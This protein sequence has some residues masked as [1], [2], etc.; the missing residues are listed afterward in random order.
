MENSLHQHFSIYE[1]MT[2]EEKKVA[3][4]LKF[5]KL[6]W[7]FE[8]PL[9]ITDHKDRPRIWT[10]DFFL[11]EFGI[12]VEV[13]GNPNIDYSFRQKIYKLENTPIIFV[14]TYKPKW[15]FFLLQRIKEIQKK[16]SILIEKIQ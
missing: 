7:V 14:H 4:F 16:R 11:S 8:Q 6:W 1:E 5:K 13:C 3:E 9:F 2:A 10:P 15:K 12:Y